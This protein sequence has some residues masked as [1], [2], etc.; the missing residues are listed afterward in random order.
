MRRTMIV[1]RIADTIKAGIHPD[2]STAAQ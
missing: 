2:D 1:L